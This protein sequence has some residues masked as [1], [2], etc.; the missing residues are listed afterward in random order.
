[1]SRLVLEIKQFFKGDVETDE[2]TLAKYSKDASLFTVKPQVVVFPK[3]VEDIKNLVKFVN[4]KK[5]EDKNLSITAR[6]AGTDMTGGPLNESMI[7]EFKRYFNHLIE[8]G[9]DYAVVEPG[10]YYRDFEKETLKHGLFLPSYPAS[11]EICAVGGMVAN[12]S[13]GEKTLTYGKTQDYVE[14]LHVVL[15]DGNE[16]IFK[17]LTREE[18]DQKLAEQTF[19]GEVYRNISKLIFDNQELLKNAK[20]KVSKNSSGYYLWDIWNGQHFDLTKL[21]TGSQGTLG[22][23]TRIKFKLVPAKKYSKLLV[24]F[25]KN[26]DPL[27]EIIHTVLPL[28]PESFEAFD[29]HT[30][31]FAMRFLLD[32]GNVLG[33][34]NLFALAFQFLP[35]LKMALT[36]G[37]PKLIMLVEFAG[38]DEKEIDEKLHTLHKELEKFE[39]QTRITKTTKEARKYWVMRRESFNL[40]RKHVSGKRTAPFI[41]DVIVNPDKLEEFMPRLNKIL[42][43]YPH[44]IYTVA[45][46]VGNGNL[47]V[48]P[49]MDLHDPSQKQLIHEISD[50]VYDLVLEFGG[51]FSAEHNDGL[52]RTP[53]MKKMFGEKVYTLFEE[54]K[55]IFDPKNILNPGKK[56]GGDIEYALNHIAKNQ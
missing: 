37:V 14:E 16:Y 17:R 24:V 25:L 51:S 29:D 19:E 1:M 33:S 26:I 41:D 11:R 30:F 43:S 3:D 15:A 40:L 20:P 2:K 54:T 47:H 34:K 56:V 8:V 12:N 48:I 42:D 28:K 52:I 32:I 7:L 35:E 6:S 45:G 44:L 39:V 4:Q 23:I 10:V 49:L 36:G 53:Y 27:V 50:K 21:I 38:D 55:R 46:H 18:L 13:G 31:K 22:I 9:E 5:S